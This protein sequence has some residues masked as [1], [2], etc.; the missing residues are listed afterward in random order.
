MQTC[1]DF[2]RAVFSIPYN[3]KFIKNIICCIIETLDKIDNA[4]RNNASP[5]TQ[6]EIAKSIETFQKSKQGLQNAN[7]EFD[8][9]VKSFFDDNPKSKPSS[10]LPI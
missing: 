1:F 10:K 7:A 2:I 3:N 5:P 4:L 6:Y 8:K 9:A